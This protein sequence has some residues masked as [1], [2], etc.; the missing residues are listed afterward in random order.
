MNI[1]I[2]GGAFNPPHIGH[3]IV[4]ESVLDQLP[5]DKVLLIP[6]AQPPNKRD[7]SL[8]PAA[9]RLEM[10]RLAIQG[11]EGYE[12]SDLEIRRGGISYTVDTVAALA[13]LYPSAS[14]SLII[15]GDNLL[16]FQTWKSPDEILARADLIV[17]NRPGFSPRDSRSE[18]L[19][20]ARMLNVPQIGISSTDVRRRVKLGRSIR[21]LVPPPVEQYILQRGLYRD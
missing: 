20:K 9:A 8:A 6:S 16:E 15:G 3:L 4:L 10:T 21:F 13:G 2:F 12:V 7:G 14:I 18:Y 17:M 1:G 19:R 11:C 5:L